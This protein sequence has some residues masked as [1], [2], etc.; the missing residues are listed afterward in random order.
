MIHIFYRHTNH[1]KIGL[2]R[3]EWFSYEKCFKNLLKTISKHENNVILNVIF[4]GEISKNPI[5]EYQHHFNTHVIN[6]GSDINSWNATNQIIK[7]QCEDGMIQPNDLIYFLENDYLHLP[8][9][10]PKVLTL[11]NTH[12]YN[13]VSLY[14]HADKY[15]DYNKL[16]SK[17][18][19]TSDCHW[20]STPSTCGSY[21]ISRETFLE[22][23]E[24]IEI[25]NR[26]C[27]DMGP[28]PDHYKFQLLTLYKK[29]QILTPIPGLS[30]HVMNGLM[31]P[32]TDWKKI[33]ELS[34]ENFSID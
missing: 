29:R 6:A 32:I 14:D 10:V 28:T 18:I 3:P 31:S 2:Y 24:E 15:F 21:I 17:I 4:D 26:L 23:F 7:S 25:I 22:D 5:Y 20:R 33:N 11:F 27:Y 13:Y 30:T 1:L 16:E 34:Y 12:P 19:A 9:W 8:E